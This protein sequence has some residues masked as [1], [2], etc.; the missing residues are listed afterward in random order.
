MDFDLSGYLETEPLAKSKPLFPLFEAI[1]NSIHAVEDTDKKD[2]QIHIHLKRDKNQYDIDKNLLRGT[3]HIIGFVITDNGIGFTEGNYKSF[4]TSY[5]TYKQ[6]RGGKGIGRLSWLQAFNETIITSTYFENDQWN[7][8]KFEFSAAHKGVG[9]PN[10]NKTDKKS[11]ETIVHL[12]GFKAQYMESASCP[13]KAETIAWKILEHCLFTFI[14]HSTIRMTLTDDDESVS[15]SLNDLYTQKVTPFA[16]EETISIKNHQFKIQHLRLYSGDSNQQHSYHLCANNR[17]VSQ[18]K[19]SNKI[20]SLI[21]KLVDEK[22]EAFYYKC[23]IEGNYLDERANSQRT[24]FTFPRDGE[25]ALNGDITKSDLIN[26]LL[27][28][29]KNHLGTHLDKLFDKITQKAERL[30]GEKYPEYRS[31]LKEFNTCVDEFSQDV[32]DEQLVT[33]MN[34][35]HFDKDMD[36]RQ[37]AQ[38]LLEKAEKGEYDKVYQEQYNHYVETI[39]DTSIVNLAKYVIHRKAILNLLEKRLESDTSG[40]YVKEEAIHEI[41]FP[42]RSNSDETEFHKCNLWIIDEKLAFHSYLSSDRPNSDLSGVPTDKKEP[43]IMVINHPSAFSDSETSPLNSIV[44][45][46]FKKPDRSSYG[47]QGESKNP[48]DQVQG[49]VGQILNN[50]ELNVRGRPILINDNTPFYC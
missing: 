36:S 48:I 1:A 28:S 16:V 26:E 11:E 3:N 29:T 9:K 31:I 24:S 41:V 25:L 13:H 6:S 49:Y 2:K 12:N 18:V 39:D 27:V 8:R 37:Q 14:R 40:K 34:Q 44:I 21:R 35:L 20:P 50:K 30:V 4:N 42:L 47:K 19:L 38:K 15:I 5:S 45:V 33:K 43:D 46:E 23:Y 22:G 7:C 10:F 32:S 17:D